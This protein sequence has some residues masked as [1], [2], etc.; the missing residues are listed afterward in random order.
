MQT[1]NKIIVSNT[2]GR[3]NNVKLSPEDND[4]GIKKDGTTHQ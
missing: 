2:S 4:D 1:K 3:A